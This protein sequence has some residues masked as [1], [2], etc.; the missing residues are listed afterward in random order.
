MATADCIPPL[1]EG[2]R[3]IPGFPCYCVCRD[4]AVFSC[5]V[6]GSRSRRLG[7]WWLLK[8][9]MRKR[10][11]WRGGYLYVDLFREVGK[12]ERQYIHQLVLEVFVG[13]CPAGGEARHLD[14]DRL[15]NLLG[16]LAWGTKLDNAAD[17]RRNGRTSVG[18]GRHNSQFTNNQVR[19]MRGLRVAGAKLKDLA[20]RFGTSKQ[21]VSAICRGRTWK[22]VV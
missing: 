5:R 19:E 21:Q 8:P 7:P 12:P 3:P 22:H 11:G 4:G 14:D 20:Q 15:N 18:E 10:V 13:P 16:N 2:A 1:P 6:Y 9:K 17:A